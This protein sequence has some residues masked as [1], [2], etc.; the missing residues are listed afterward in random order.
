MG[1]ILEAT[2]SYLG[3]LYFTMSRDFLSGLG[4]SFVM[5]GR[6]PACRHLAAAAA[7]LSPKKATAN[8]AEGDATRQRRPSFDA[9]AE[10]RIHG[11]LV[12][13]A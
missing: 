5:P 13:T 1:G 7:A 2:S 11:E 6:P 3:H 10:D 9:E 8:K 4:Q 12:S